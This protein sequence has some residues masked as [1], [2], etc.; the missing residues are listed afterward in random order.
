MHVCKY[1]CSMSVCMSMCVD[2]Y[3]LDLSKTKV[4]KLKTRPRHSVQDSRQDQDIGSK[5]Q[6]KTK[7]LKSRSQDISRQDL[8]SRDYITGISYLPQMLKARSFY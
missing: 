1:V 6:D 3:V 5:T 2:T 7:T 8:K 4:S